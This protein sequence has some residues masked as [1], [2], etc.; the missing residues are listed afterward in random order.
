M[1]LNY[2]KGWQFPSLADLIRKVVEWLSPRKTDQDKKGTAADEAAKKAAEAASYSIMSAPGLEKETASLTDHL[3]TF[4]QVV[5][6]SSDLTYAKKLTGQLAPE[7]PPELTP[8]ELP[9]EEQKEKEALK[10]MLWLPGGIRWPIEP[11]SSADPEVAASALAGQGATGMLALAL[12]HTPGIVAEAASLGQIET[13]TWTIMDLLNATGLPDMVKQANLLPFEVGVLSPARMHYNQLYRPTYPGPAQLPALLAR[14]Q[15][16]EAEYLEIHGYHGYDGRWAAATWNAFLRLPEFRDLAVMLWRGMID[17]VGFKDTMLRQGW[18]LD[19]VDE[20]LN[21]AWQIP[22]PQDLIT[23]VVREVISPQD[24]ISQME[25]QGYGPGW[26]GAY[27]TAH[28][29]LPAPDML[30]E[31]MHREIITDAELQKFIFWHDFNPEPR[32]GISRSDLSIYRAM[33]KRL[34]PRVDLRRGWERGR[35][36]D[37]ELVRRYRWLGYEDD[38]ELMAE[39]QKAVAMDAE[40]NAIAAAAASLYREGNM[41]PDE[42]EGWL[43]LADFSEVRI[44]KVRAAEDL[45]YRLDF[46][47]DLE[48]LAIQAYQKDVFTL[49]E[50]EA[51]LLRIGKQ[52][53]R[54]DA[55]IAK[56]AYKKL[57]KPK[58]AAG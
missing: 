42:F 58:A 37:Q 45:K 54:V 8:P 5:D 49:D 25:K 3:A 50:L 10:N 20:M 36:S 40:N 32:P 51:E 19:V 57:P 38:A 46:I 22:G 48:S 39:I 1:P 17:N 35:I 16:T 27:W 6:P 53:E 43:R 15:V 2:H 7:P 56:E 29:R 34:I 52:P 30:I 31:A 44:Q 24:F 28:F 33:T 26:A 12:A 9:P 41:T 21:L 14:R 23:F 47:K 11:F 4:Q 18:H 55:M 13:V